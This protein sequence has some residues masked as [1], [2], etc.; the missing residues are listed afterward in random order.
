ML[1]EAKSEVLCATS[2]YEKIGAMKKV[3]HCGA[4]LQ[5]I[6]KGTNEPVTS[7]K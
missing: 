7:L 3:G 5:M 2:I 1:K 4:I 6:E